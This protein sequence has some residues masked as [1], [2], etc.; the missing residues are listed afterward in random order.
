MGWRNKLKAEEITE[1]MGYS[2]SRTPHGHHLV[3]GPSH[4]QSQ[5]DIHI[6][7]FWGSPGTWLR[8]TDSLSILATSN[9]FVHSANGDLQ[10]QFSSWM[11]ARR[12]LGEKNSSLE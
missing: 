5:V 7:D 3:S 4:W 6:G 9:S 10:A 2:K 1:D 12:P 8:A 11:L